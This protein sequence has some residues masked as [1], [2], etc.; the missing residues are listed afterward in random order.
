VT[1]R[2]VYD[3]TPCDWRT[4][5]E[6]ARLCE[7]CGWPTGLDCD[8]LDDDNAGDAQAVTEHLARLVAWGMAERDG[9]GRR[10]RARPATRPAGLCDVWRYRGRP[11]PPRAHPD[12]ETRAAWVRNWSFVFGLSCVTLYDVTGLSWRLPATPKA[13]ETA[14]CA[15]ADVDAAVESDADADACA[16]PPRPL[17]QWEFCHRRG[18]RLTVEQ[19]TERGCREWCAAKTAA[20]AEATAAAKKGI[21]T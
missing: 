10:Y 2:D 5:A 8:D 3:A 12:P 1:P 18:Y 20:E 21:R 6:V 19:H 16:E 11:M 9:E 13:G 4:P 7:L 17:R 15:D 14:T